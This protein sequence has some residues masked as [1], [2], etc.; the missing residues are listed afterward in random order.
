MLKSGTYIVI[1]ATS[2]L[3][4][5]AANADIAPS[6][7]VSDDYGAVEKSLTKATGD[8]VS[9]RKVFINRKQGNCLACHVNSEMS[10]QTFHGEVGPSLDGVADRWTQGELRGIIINSKKVFEGTIMPAFYRDAGFNRI[11]KKFEGKTILKAQEVEDVVSYLL[12][13]KE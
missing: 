12:T 2:L 8:P 10:E 13:L 7:V 3:V 11:L 5:Q 4:L 1:V 6:E 9:G